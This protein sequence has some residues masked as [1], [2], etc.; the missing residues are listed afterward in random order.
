MTIGL[1]ERQDFE[2]IP[3]KVEYSLSP[4]GHSLIPV[5]S[6]MYEWGV[7]HLVKDSTLRKLGVKRS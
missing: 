1:I 6:G 7:K 3:R 2:V 4:E 5:I